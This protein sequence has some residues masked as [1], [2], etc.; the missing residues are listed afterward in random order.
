MP[1]PTQPRAI[2]DQFRANFSGDFQRLYELVIGGTDVEA[3]HVI[4]FAASQFDEG[5]TSIT[6]GFAGF[7]AGLHSKDQVIAVEG[8]LRRPSFQEIFGLDSPIGLQ[9]VLEGR[10]QLD[11]AIVGPTEAGFSLLTAD[12][13]SGKADLLSWDS[14]RA[15]LTRTFGALRERFRFVLVDSPPIIPFVDGCILCANTYGV[16]FVVESNRT[17]AEVVNQALE[18]LKS[19]GANILGIILNKRVFHIPNFIYR[20]L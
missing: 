4:Q 6:L 13:T 1:R 11:D 16:V 15:G 10:V 19:G 2:L 5:T 8:N 12:K 14:S 20:F 18:M 7:L 9:A 17:R 3:S